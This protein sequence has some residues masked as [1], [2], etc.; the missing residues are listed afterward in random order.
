MTRKATSSIPSLDGAQLKVGRAREHI[1][2]LEA[3]TAHFVN[4]S[5]AYEF[6]TEPDPETDGV[7]AKIHVHGTPPVHL[8]LVAGDVVHNLRSALDHLVWQ[9]G[10]ADNKHVSSR[11]QWPIV[12]DGKNWPSEAGDRLALLSPPHVEAIRL[13]Q[14]FADMRDNSPGVMLGML[15]ALSNRDKHRLPLLVAAAA[16]TGQLT[17][18]PAVRRVTIT[19]VGDGP[20]ELVEGAEL[21]RIHGGRSRTGIV[22]AEGLFQIVV[23]YGHRDGPTV[24]NLRDLADLIVG[25]I[26]TFALDL[27]T[28]T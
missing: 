14:P 21:V 10:I 28:A 2:A 4:D 13:L 18:D 6:Y 27:A 16:R 8:A 15:G 12:M 20:I 1:D 17:F 24:K 5:G 19:R 23:A 11:S 25:I 9:V 7:I 3:E 22:S 26:A